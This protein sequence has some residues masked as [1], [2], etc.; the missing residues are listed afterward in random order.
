MAMMITTSTVSLRS[1][2]NTGMEKR[3]LPVLS[4]THTLSRILCTMVLGKDDAA[5]KIVRTRRISFAF[6]QL[7]GASISAVLASLVE[8]R[9]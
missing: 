6:F 8:E 3:L 9:H 4:V 7:K 5:L 2:K 1:T